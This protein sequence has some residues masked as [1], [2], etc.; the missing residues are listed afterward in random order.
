MAGATKHTVLVIDDDDALRRVITRALERSGYAVLTAANGEEGLR[1]A[2][3]ARPMV[4]LVDLRMPRMDGLTFLRHAA[5]HHLDAVVVAT[6][7]DVE[8]ADLVE[9]ERHGA[10]EF[11]AKPWNPSQLRAIVG[12]AAE[13]YDKHHPA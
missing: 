9:L 4:I 5:S 8:A 10:V 12:R 13:R 11:L 6:S 2:L 3:A 1:I 7:G